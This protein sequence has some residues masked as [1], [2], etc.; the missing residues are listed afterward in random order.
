MAIT[1]QTMADTHFH[2]SCYSSA[3]LLFILPLF[4]DGATNEIKLSNQWL[5]A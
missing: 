4:T 3:K 5:L 1:L 2:F